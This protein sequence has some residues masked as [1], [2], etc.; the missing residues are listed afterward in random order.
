MRARKNA[1]RLIALLLAALMVLGTVTGVLLS[2]RSRTN[3]KSWWTGELAI[4]NSQ[5][6]PCCAWRLAAFPCSLGL[7]RAAS[8]TG[9]ALRAPPA[10]AILN[11]QWSFRVVRKA[12]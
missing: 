6:S 11:S 5:W 10:T 4:H 7:L 2:M 8:P 3:L 1:A 9:R 12:H